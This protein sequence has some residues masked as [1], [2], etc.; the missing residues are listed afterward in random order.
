[1]VTIANDLNS[2]ET[3]LELLNPLLDLLEGAENL[4]SL[5]GLLAFTGGDVFTQG[6]ATAF[7]ESGVI[8]NPE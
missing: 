8:A 4:G 5:G 1:L 3:L 2:T 6:L 7:S